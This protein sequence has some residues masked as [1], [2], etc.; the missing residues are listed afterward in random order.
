MAL[1]R[2]VNK[3]AWE[4]VRVARPWGKISKVH[5]SLILSFFLFNLVMTLWR[6]QNSPDQRETRT[7]GVL[8]NFFI[9][10]NSAFSDISLNFNQGSEDFLNSTNYL[11]W[12]KQKKRN[13]RIKSVDHEC[14]LFLGV[15]CEEM[16][17]VCA[18]VSTSACVCVGA[19]EWVRERERLGEIQYVLAQTESYNVSELALKSWA[20]SINLSRSGITT[21]CITTPSS[22]LGYLD[23]ERIYL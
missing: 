11:M 12:K 10:Y 8:C 3:K 13:M 23:S 22:K 4:S 19:C 5:R 17:G 21:P 16:T 7:K 1:P 20:F 15:D 6:L 18:C 2:S 9:S 14:S